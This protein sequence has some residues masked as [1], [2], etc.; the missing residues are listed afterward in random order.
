M[1]AVRDDEELKVQLLGLLAEV[2]VS[3]QQIRDMLGTPTLAFPF[4]GRCCTLQCDDRHA[5][6]GVMQPFVCRQLGRD[7]AQYADGIMQ[8]VTQIQEQT[9]SF[10][11][12]I[13]VMI[14]VTVFLIGWITVR[15]VEF[16]Q[17]M[18]TG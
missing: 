14:L 6:N 4:C 12:K 18:F 2:D 10:V 17:Q 5:P 15:M 16:S 3:T 8:A 7:S 1:A 13:A 9:L 11:P